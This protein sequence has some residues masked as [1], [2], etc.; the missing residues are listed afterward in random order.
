MSTETT[1]VEQTSESTGG[2]GFTAEER[3]Y[4]ESRGE[5]FALTDP[6]STPAEAAKPAVEQTETA[7]PADEDVPDGTITLDEA[8]LKRDKRT[9]RFVP[10][11]AFHKERENRKAAETQLAQLREERARINE[12]LSILTQAFN[13]GDA[14]PQ[15]AAPAEEAV[16][17]PETDIFGYVRHAGKEIAALKAQLAETKKATVERL[18]ATEAGNAYVND[19][20][21]FSREKTDFPSAYQHLVKALSAE[22]EFMGVTD[23]KQRMAEI[24]RLEREQVAIARQ[25]GERPAERIYKLA[26]MRG[27][28]AAPAQK[29]VEP[30][31]AKPALAENLE[32]VERGQNAA[33]SLS[34]AGGGAPAQLTAE[35]MLNMSD[36]EFA[37]ALSKMGGNANQALRKLL[38]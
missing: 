26:A 36:A 14:T 34:S 9:G 28:T 10:H 7:A 29:A 5:K 33:R 32:R 2:D 22:L 18:D 31:A 23:E 8:G 30:G 37:A 4:F 38:G 16:P 3:S 35:A 15:Q 6:E 25:R 21:A 19:A 24:A 20:I 13:Q 17:D 12:R 1:T 27:Y 11:G